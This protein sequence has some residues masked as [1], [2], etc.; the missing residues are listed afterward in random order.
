MDIEVNLLYS[1]HIER[2]KP[3]KP[4]TDMTT[5]KNNADTDLDLSFR[6]FFELM[7]RRVNEILLVSS[8]YDAFIME[9]DGR[10][11]ERI[12]HEYRGL[13]LTRPPR[14][15]YKS[16]AK[17]ALA[18]L[19]HK[20]FDLVLTMPRIDDMDYYAFAREVKKQYEHLPV[21]LLTHDTGQ[22]SAPKKFPSP[23]SIDRTFVWLGNTDLL[24]AVIKSVEDRMN[25]AHDTKRALVRV[26][27]LVEDSPFYRSSIL[28]LLYKEIVMQTQ[29]VMEES[30]NEAHRILRMRARP[31]ILL[32]ENFEEALQLYQDFKPYVLSVLSDVRFEW[33]GQM[34]DQAGFRLLSVVK[35][36]TPDIPL[37]VFSSEE[38]NRTRAEEI[39]AAFINKHS[40]SLHSEIQTFFKNYLGF[41]EF[42]FRL[43]DGTEVGRAQNILAMERILPTLPEESIYYHAV[44]DDFSTW[45]MARSEIQLASRLRPVKA[46]D[47][48]SRKAAIDY[49]IAY[50]RKMRRDRR[51]GVIVDF[52]PEEFDPE[53]DFIKV[54]K[55][56]LGGKARGLAFV[57]DLLKQNSDLEEKFP[58]I[59]ITVPPM[60]VISTDGFEE[61]VNENGLKRLASGDHYDTDI[62]KEFLAGRFPDRLT[63]VLDIF[64]KDITYPLAV[65]SSSLFEDALYHPCAG[66]YNTCML[67]N[68]HSDP[69]V[70]RNQL[71]RAIKLVYASTYLEAPRAFAGR[72]GHRIEDEK[73]GV[74]IQKVTGEPYGNVFYPAVSGVAQSY[75][76][77]PISYMTPN[78]GIVHIALGLGKTVVE[79]GTSLRFCPKYPQF[80]PQFSTVK[81][82]L[83]NS[84]RSFFALNMNHNVVEFGPTVDS[85]LIRMDFDDAVDH[86]AVRRLS[87]AYMPEDDRIRDGFQGSGYP[88]LTFA[89][90]LKYG[91]WPLPEIIIDLLRLGRRGLGCPVEIEF[92][93]NLPEDTGRK[94]QFSILQLRPMALGLIGSEIEITDRDIKEAVC[95]SKKAMGNGFLE[96]VTDIIY[97]NPDT[98]D[99]ARTVEMARIIGKLN[100]ELRRQGRRYLLIGPGRWGSADRWLGIPVNWADISG[101]GAIIETTVKNLH[102]D[103]SQGTHFFHNIVSIGISYITV[104]KNDEGFIDWQWLQSLPAEK[105]V[106]SVRHVKLKQPLTI[107]I[108]GKTSFAVILKNEGVME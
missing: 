79:G 105:E 9:E 20:R 97:V 54:G 86:P 35:Q 28:P 60:M 74:I 51:R 91:L 33:R 11:A 5:E 41:G 27:I 44:H 48:S 13:N 95:F 50:I 2:R 62:V 71:I 98:F 89:G 84:Q 25:V 16:T 22:L 102:A 87:S 18:A 66:I 103:P 64:L 10:L 46:T 83:S 108:D 65:R 14:L 96:N 73:M 36:E 68:I 49:L 23:V 38:S 47:F 63:E 40:P 77:Y 76:F 106:C 24:L 19:S 90:I 7:A 88:V 45:L 75:N 43:P 78:E 70:R 1:P 4:E 72:T 34:D 93:L 82:T 69:T 17:D 31:K 59:D 61:F 57:W 21:F 30:L 100:S 15:T 8:P 92:S 81:E 56:S 58:E 55:G 12:I 104:Q 85:T 52:S 3:T 80:I 32:A 107:K 53:T 42:I 94:A 26:I 101:V 67:P 99:P 6:V 39:P 29:A 37:L